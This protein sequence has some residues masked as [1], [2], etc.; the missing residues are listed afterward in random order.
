MLKVRAPTVQRFY[1]DPSIAS[2]KEIEGKY[3]NKTEREVND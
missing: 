2:S 3:S 1:P